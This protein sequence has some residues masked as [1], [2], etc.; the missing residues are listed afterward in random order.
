MADELKDMI[1]E[2]V[3][4]ALYAI[5]KIRPEI[6][7]GNF[8][9]VVKMTQYLYLLVK[10]AALFQERNFTGVPIIEY[11]KFDNPHND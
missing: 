2:T 7:R 5:D 9:A 4:S 6:E 10:Y 8:L 11:P 1:P 3:D